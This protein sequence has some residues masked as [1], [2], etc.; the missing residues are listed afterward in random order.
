MREAMLLRGQFQ[1]ALPGALTL[2]VKEP[3]LSMAWLASSCIRDKC[4]RWFSLPNA[5][6]DVAM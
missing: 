2:V 6:T 4:G 1:A 5:H 3:L